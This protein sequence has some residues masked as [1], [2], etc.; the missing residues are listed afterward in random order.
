MAKWGNCAVPYTPR[1]VVQFVSKQNP[2]DMM[3]LIFQYELAIVPAQAADRQT[4]RDALNEFAHRAIPRI[5]SRR[6][7]A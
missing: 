5:G 7:I 4:Y 2:A 1:P 6:A 3:S